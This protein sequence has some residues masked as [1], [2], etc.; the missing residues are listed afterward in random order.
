MKIRAL[1]AIAAASV[2]VLAPL[3]AQ[4]GTKA[5]AVSGPVSYGARSTASVK[6]SKNATEFAWVIIGLTAAGAAIWGLVEVLDDG[7]TDGAN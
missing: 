2:T 4:A 1:A 7:K 6:A 5:S 3:A